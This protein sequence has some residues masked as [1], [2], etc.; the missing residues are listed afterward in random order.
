MT[1][2]K[3]AKAAVKRS[4]EEYRGGERRGAAITSCVASEVE[5]E[6]GN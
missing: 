1:K 2:E 3:E 5:Q 6:T 4:K